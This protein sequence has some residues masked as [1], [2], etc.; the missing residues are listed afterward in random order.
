MEE[1]KASDPTIET[2]RQII[3]EQE[4][5]IHGLKET[6]A[7]QEARLKQLDKLNMLPAAVVEMEKFN[8]AMKGSL[9]TVL[10]V[11]SLYRKVLA[12]LALF[13]VAVLFAGYQCYAAHQA[14]EE[15]ASLIDNGIYTPEGWSRIPDSKSDVEHRKK[16]AEQEAE[17]KKPSAEN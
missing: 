11:A 10:D 8:N 14:A 1:E 13:V 15:A 12:V 2:L 9:D 5:E 6:N 4:A 3:R 7:K 17:K 16:I